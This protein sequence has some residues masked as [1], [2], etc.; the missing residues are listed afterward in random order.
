MPIG[1][2]KNVEYKQGHSVRFDVSSVLDQLHIKNEQ[3]LVIGPGAADQTHLSLNGELVFNMTLDQY[4]KVITQRSYSSVISEED[5]P[6][7]SLYQPKTCGPFQHI[8]ISSKDGTQSPILIEIDVHER[9]TTEHEEENNFISVI[10]RSLKQYSKEPIA[11]GG[12][13]RVE[14]GTI[15]AHIMPDFVNED[16]TTKKQVDEWLKFY[17]MDAPLNC[18]SVLLTEDINNA[19][20]RLEHSHFFSDHGQAGHYHFDITPKEVHYHG[21]F[22]VCNEA[23]IIDPVV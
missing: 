5:E 21:Y 12:I 4:N 10:R 18:V 1:G 15:K 16:L 3:T 22:M 11:L 20:F 19:G 8:M 13:F 14:K 2:A 23:I 7:Q 17:D 6:C 9:L